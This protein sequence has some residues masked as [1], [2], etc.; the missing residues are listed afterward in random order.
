MI[1]LGSGQGPGPN[2]LSQLLALELQAAELAPRS[3]S[4]TVDL[5]ALLPRTKSTSSAPGWEKDPPFSHCPNQ[6]PGVPISSLC[7]PHSDILC[8]Q[9]ITWPWQLFASL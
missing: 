3:V 5:P 2:F 6:K 4:R 8:T 1:E 9:S 7:L